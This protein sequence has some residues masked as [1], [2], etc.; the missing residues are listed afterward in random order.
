MAESDPRQLTGKQGESLARQEL[1]RRGYAIL[2]TGFRT[3]YGEIDIIARH[4]PTL[5]FVEVRTRNARD[6]GT[7]AESVTPRKQW[8]VSR[9]ASAYLAARGGADEPCRFDVVAID[10]DAAGTPAI[11]VYESAF[12]SCY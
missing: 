9:A 6:C 4:G 12:D 2:D 8:K 5:V 3:R 7:A 10:F 1:E 11:T